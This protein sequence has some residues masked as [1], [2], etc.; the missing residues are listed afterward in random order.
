[1]F[2]VPWTTLDDK[3]AAAAHRLALLRI[4]ELEK[5]LCNLR[6]AGCEFEDTGTAMI[7]LPAWR[8]SLD[9]LKK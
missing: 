9:V 6:D 5:A 4:V 3:V 1:M 8:E 7:A 2:R